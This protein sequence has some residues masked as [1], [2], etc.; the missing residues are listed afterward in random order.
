[1]K[2]FC[3]IAIFS[4]FCVSS[5]SAEIRN[6]FPG[7]EVEMNDLDLGVSSVRL[8][9]I[10]P[11]G[12][13]CMDIAVSFKHD[14]KEELQLKAT[15]SA[16]GRSISMY[17]FPPSFKGQRFQVKEAQYSG[18]EHNG[19]KLYVQPGMYEVSGLKATLRVE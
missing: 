1:M 16:D 8:C 9:I 4:L 2:N 3:V 7:V 15:L 17:G 19:K 13:I 10:T 12:S 11:A 14:I 5:L 18:F 6:D